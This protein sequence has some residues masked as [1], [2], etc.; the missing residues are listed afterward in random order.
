MGA[1]TVFALI[2]KFIWDK[3][4]Y[5]ANIFFGGGPQNWGGGF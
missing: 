4:P 5:K 2:R 3:F 1:A